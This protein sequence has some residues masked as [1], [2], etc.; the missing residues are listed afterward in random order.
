MRSRQGILRATLAPQ[1]ALFSPVA[2]AS[3]YGGLGVLMGIALWAIPF[4][5]VSALFSYWA[6]SRQRYSSVAFAARHRM[7]SLAF[8][9]PGFALTIMSADTNEAR[10]NPLVFPVM[11]CVFCGPPLLFAWL[12]GKLND[13]QRKA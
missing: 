7:I 8:V 11:F 4:A 12:P 10:S 5:I 13:R 2:A 1:I 9:V 6:Y 3:D